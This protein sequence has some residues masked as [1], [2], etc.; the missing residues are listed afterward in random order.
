MATTLATRFLIAIPD[1]RWTSRTAPTFPP[2]FGSGRPTRFT[3][4]Q[5]AAERLL[6]NAWE[7]SQGDL[8]GAFILTEIE[9]DADSLRHVFRNHPAWGT[10]IVSVRKGVY[11]LAEPR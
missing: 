3:P 5:A 7:S 2:S 4:K 10:M 6:W 8:S 1:E 9:S 11:A